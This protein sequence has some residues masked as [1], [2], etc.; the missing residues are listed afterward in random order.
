LFFNLL[1]FFRQLSPAGEK[2]FYCIIFER[3]RQTCMGHTVVVKPFLKFYS[4]EQLQNNVWFEQ[5]CSW[6]AKLVR[7]AIREIEG[8]IRVM[9]Q[10]F[11]RY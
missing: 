4:D 1:P 7:Q 5:S 8:E 9:R 3:E 6:F 2:D 10:Y 11:F